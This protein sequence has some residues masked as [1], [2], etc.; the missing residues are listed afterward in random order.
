MPRSC[1]HLYSRRLLT[2]ISRRSASGSMR[3]A[4]STRRVHSGPNLR[5]VGGTLLMLSCSEGQESMVNLLVEHKASVDLP[6]G[7]PVAP[8]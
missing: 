8:L 4:T 1:H 2:V 6:D 3:A 7:R 5:L